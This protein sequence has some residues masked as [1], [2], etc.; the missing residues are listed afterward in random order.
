MDDLTRGRITSAIIGRPREAI[1]DGR[2]LRFYPATLGGSLVISAE[3]GRITSGR[4]PETAREIADLA[5]RDPE[6]VARVIAMSA[7]KGREVLD[8]AAVEETAKWLTER[9]DP[10][11]LSE[12]LLAALGEDSAERIIDAC[13]LRE[14]QNERRELARRKMAGARQRTY[15]GK[16]LWGTLITPGCE[17]YGCTPETV[18]WEVS[19]MSLRMTLADRIESVALSDDDM[20]ALGLDGGE[21]LD[22]ESMSIEELMSLTEE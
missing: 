8:T 21:T 22:G 3:L 13:G 15:G 5:R 10:A 11:G 1:V 14:E 20:K 19:L 4:L 2:R 7:Q 9:V 16:T 17:L 6:G 12:L 18:I